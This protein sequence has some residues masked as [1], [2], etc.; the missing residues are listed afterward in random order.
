MTPAGRALALAVV[1]AGC[2]GE[3]EH[4]ER[5]ADCPPGFVEQLFMERC[6]G[7]CHDGAAPEAGLDLVSTGVA[8]RLVGVV[9][10]QEVCDG[11]PL[12]DP[13]GGDHLLLDKLGT[14]PRCGS[15]MPLGETALDPAEVE[16][17]RRWID[18]AVAAAGGS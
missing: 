8:T 13:A 11:A 10:A 7:A 18:E 2:A 16:C 1:M 12:V 17:V 5:F 9:S 6:A 3:L 4:P 15:P 14:R